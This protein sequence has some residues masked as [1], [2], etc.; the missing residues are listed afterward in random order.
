MS[1]PGD[2]ASGDRPEQ[3]GPGLPREPGTYDPPELR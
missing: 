3:A 1:G 2:S